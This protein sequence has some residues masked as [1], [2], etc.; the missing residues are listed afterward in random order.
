MIAGE[1]TSGPLRLGRTR[2]KMN[3]RRV[4]HDGGSRLSGPQAV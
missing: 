3:L 4:P 2:G 1:G